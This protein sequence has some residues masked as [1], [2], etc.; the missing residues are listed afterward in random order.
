M[1]GMQE[2]CI[3]VKNDIFSKSICEMA[4]IKNS[5]LDV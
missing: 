5:N 2:A 1:E 3:E 4:R